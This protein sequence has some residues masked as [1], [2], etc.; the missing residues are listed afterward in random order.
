MKYNYQ[1]DHYSKCSNGPRGKVNLCGIFWPSD[2]NCY[3]VGQA[4]RKV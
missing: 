3:T 1:V 2:N 4:K